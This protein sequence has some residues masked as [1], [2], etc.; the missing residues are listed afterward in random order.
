M[1][2]KPS[3]N[4]DEVCYPFIHET[5]ELCDFEVITD[6]LCGHIGEIIDLMPFDDLRT[7]LEHLQPLAFH[8][9]GSIRGRLAVDEADLTWLQGR[10]S[11]YR[12]EV[13]TRLQSFVLPR[14]SAPVPQLHHARSCAKKAI[15]AMVRVDQEGIDV[16]PILP[17]LCNM[18]V[19]VFFVMTLVINQRR[20]IS[21]VE[22]VSKSYGKR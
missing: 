9:N 10:L 2:L 3:R 8:V 14:G 1:A 21:E 20:G 12:V 11:H 15:R 7:D 22:F 5:S 13:S 16:P 4:W 19:N 17:R 18:M 6:E